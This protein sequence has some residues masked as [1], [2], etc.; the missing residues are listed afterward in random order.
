M[1]KTEWV[2]TKYHMITK[3]CNNFSDEFCKALCNRGIPSWVNRLA[4]VANTFPFLI[5][6]L[7]A[8]YF[9]PVA[10]QKKLKREQELKYN[11][12][13]KIVAKKKKE[14]KRSRSSQD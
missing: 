8:E 1:G 9:T 6:L 13:K 2:G 11:L 14:K 3:N 10:L 4:K 7:P 5:R 12:S